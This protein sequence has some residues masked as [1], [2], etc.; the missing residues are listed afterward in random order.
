MKKE[1]QKKDRKNFKKSEVIILLGITSFISII[2][3]FTISSISG[4]SIKIN[5]IIG[6]KA[7]S[8][9]MN[10]EHLQKFIDNYEYIINNYYEKIDREKLIDDAIAGM[11][12]TLDDPYSVYMDENSSSSFN[13]SLDG[14]YQGLGI[15]VIKDDDKKAILI[16]SVFKNSPA[17]KSGLKAGDYI[18]KVNNIDLSEKTATEF[19]DV[20]LKGEG[21]KFILNVI[22]DDKEE[23][24][25]VIRDNVTIN[26]VTSKVYEKNDKKIGY[27]YISI[28]ANNTSKQFKDQLKKLEKEKIDS[29]IIDVR[30]NT[31]G[32]LTSVETILNSLLTKN[33]ITYQLNK[34]N[35][36]IKYY[37]KAKEN[38]KYNIV[39]LG[40]KNS[41][42]ASEILIASLR[43]N[44]GAKFIG[45]KTYGKGTV[46]ELITMTDGEQYKITTKKWLTPNGNW[47]NDTKGIK[48][49]IEV[50]MD[51]SVY[52]D[53]SEHKDVQ[54]KKALE[55]LTE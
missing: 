29:L 8:T 35:K 34:K 48:P 14:E 6:N 37:G 16:L 5:S 9:S 46:Q 30:E 17:E 20:I 28:F 7:T 21:K 45:T 32:H 4:L 33:Q 25:E 51:E 47:I 12:E 19:S 53:Y 23:Q 13:I 49:D 40:D 31:G 38:K 15:Q 43:E 36:T 3:G 50:D 18:T 27:I 10:D 55:Y 24:I 22:R 2:L 1:K 39:L 11:M 41:A 54:L 26:S 44:L 42:S 52:N